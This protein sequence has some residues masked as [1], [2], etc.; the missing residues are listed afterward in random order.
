MPSCMV[1]MALRPSLRSE[2]DSNANQQ[3]DN[4]T[5]IGVA[6]LPT[7][8]FSVDCFF[9]FSEGDCKDG[10]LQEQEAEE[11]KSQEE[12]QEEKDSFS[13]SISSQ[14]SQDRVDDDNNSNSSGFSDSLFAHELPLPVSLVFLSIKFKTVPNFSSL[15]F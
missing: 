14:E 6:P 8:D 1:N 3:A 7:E 11:L 5:T 15:L 10:L 9:D 13:E 2:L 4:T 12:E